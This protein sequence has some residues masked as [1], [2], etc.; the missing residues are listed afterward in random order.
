MGFK[1][2][3]YATF[4][5]RYRRRLTNCRTLEEM[6]AHAP[7]DHRLQKLLVVYAMKDK[8]TYNKMLRLAR[9]NPYA[10]ELVEHVKATVNYVSRQRNP[11]MQELTNHLRS[12]TGFVP[13]TRPLAVLGKRPGVSKLELDGYYKM[14]NNYLSENRMGNATPEL[15]ARVEARLEKVDFNKL[16]LK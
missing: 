13:R 5:E 1:R 11:E 10:Q 7:N 2:N 9:V 4:M 16:V 3:G 6:L 8:T 12:V 15:K 14:L